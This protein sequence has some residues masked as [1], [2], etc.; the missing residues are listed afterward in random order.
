MQ[1]D[2]ALAIGQRCGEVQNRCALRPVRQ[3]IESRQEKRPRRHTHQ[4]QTQFG[5]N[6]QGWRKN[7]ERRKVARIGKL[8]K[9]LKHR[10]SDGIK[11]AFAGRQR[12]HFRRLEQRLKKL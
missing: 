11:K 3:G 5:C 12:R 9:A 8:A 7:K 6:R 4:R 10:R 1:Q 2:K